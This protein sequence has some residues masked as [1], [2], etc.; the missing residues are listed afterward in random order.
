MSKVKLLEELLAKTIELNLELH[1]IWFDSYLYHRGD[2]KLSLVYA[3]A[4]DHGYWRK[5]RGALTPNKISHTHK[6]R[7]EDFYRRKLDASWFIKFIYDNTF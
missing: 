5:V 3:V 6:I 2:G 4:D 7:T 1:I